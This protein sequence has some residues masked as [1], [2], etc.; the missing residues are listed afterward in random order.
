MLWAK[1][2]VTPPRRCLKTV[3]SLGFM[4]TLKASFTDEI[5]IQKEID[6]RT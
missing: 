1:A 6:G 3:G 5:V 2:P 4:Q